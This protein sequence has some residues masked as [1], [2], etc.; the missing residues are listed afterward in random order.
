MGPEL[1]TSQINLA[2]AKAQTYVCDDI[3]DEKINKVMKNQLMNYQI[4]VKNEIFYL[5]PVNKTN[6]LNTPRLQIILV[7]LSS[8]NVAT[9]FGHAGDF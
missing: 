5:E 6:K 2:V 7:V 4:L 8:F 9:F 1:F 3:N